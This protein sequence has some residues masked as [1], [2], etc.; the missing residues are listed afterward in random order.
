MASHSLQKEKDEFRMEKMD[1]H[2]TFSP[3][4]FPGAEC[5]HLV[6]VAPREHRMGIDGQH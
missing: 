5:Y 1:L 4:T 2:F 6:L 3:V